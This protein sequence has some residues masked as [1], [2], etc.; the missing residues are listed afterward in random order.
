[1]KGKHYVST[2]PGILN[3]FRHFRWILSCP[4]WKF[5]P[6]EY[7]NHLALQTM[8]QKVVKIKI[9]HQFQN[10]KSFITFKFCG[11]KL[12]PIWHNSKLNK[13]KEHVGPWTRPKWLRH[14]KAIGKVAP[15][16]LLT[17]KITSVIECTIHLNKKK[18][19]RKP[20][21]TLKVF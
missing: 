18:R 8:F 1:M 4:R 15:R 11:Q 9:H 3:I 13:T 19:Q 14:K 5:L 7:C 17:S 6:R 20:P 16:L 21:G 10:E 2:P 12:S